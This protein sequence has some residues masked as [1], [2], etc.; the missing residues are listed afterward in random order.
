MDF[1]NRSDRLAVNKMQFN[2]LK[3]N[4]DK[5]YYN[6]NFNLLLNGGYHATY[7]INYHIDRTF[8]N[9]RAGPEI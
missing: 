8:D 5:S 6:E 7:F 3:G 1:F 2:Y 9:H 4:K